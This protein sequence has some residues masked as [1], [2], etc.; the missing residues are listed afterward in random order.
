MAKAVWG[1]IILAPGASTT[2]WHTWGFADTHFVR[3]DACP[4][5]TNSCVEI[6]RQ[7]ACKDIYGTVLRW[8]TFRNNGG[9]LV[10][11]RRTCIKE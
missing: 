6:T 5:S 11:F 1:T 2:W 10:R 9:T 3:F 8:V 4:T 7:W